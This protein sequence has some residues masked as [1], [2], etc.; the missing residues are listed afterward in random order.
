MQY[1]I[2]L[3][4]L[5]STYTTHISNTTSNSLVCDV[6]GTYSGTAVSS[7]GQYITEAYTLKEN[8]FAVGTLTVG[9]KGVTFGGYRNTCDS[10]IISAHYEGNDHYYILRGA[11]N[12]DRSFLSGTY[13]DLN[14][15]IHGTFRF[16]KM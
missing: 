4:F 9:G 16:R 3:A 7:K 12:K 10:V 2:L 6:K 13:K 15:G 8:N 5:A 1:L 11:F 14:S